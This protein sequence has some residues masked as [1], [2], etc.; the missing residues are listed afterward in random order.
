M[1]HIATYVA[2]NKLGKVRNS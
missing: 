2:V 1:P